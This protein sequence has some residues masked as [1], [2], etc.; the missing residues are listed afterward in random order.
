MLSAGYGVF[1]LVL[2]VVCSYSYPENAVR[3]S[4]H[5][6]LDVEQ[7]QANS[8]LNNNFA[9]HTYGQNANYKTMGDTPVVSVVEEKF[10]YAPGPDSEDWA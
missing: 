5:R 1:V 9:N 10:I 6:R 3:R 4:M 7:H 2:F 8:L